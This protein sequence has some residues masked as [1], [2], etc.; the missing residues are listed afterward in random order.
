MRSILLIY[1]NT[2]NNFFL[3]NLILIFD[4]LFHGKLFNKFGSRADTFTR[5]HLEYAQ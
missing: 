5:I 1:L 4:I 3:K 2:S